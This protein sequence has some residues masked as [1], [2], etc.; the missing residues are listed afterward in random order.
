MEGEKAKLELI[1]PKKQPTNTNQLNALNIQVQQESTQTYA[2]YAE[3]FSEALRNTL[4]TI[5][6]AETFEPTNDTKRCEKCA[7][8]ILCW[9]AKG[10]TN[11]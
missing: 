5:L 4:A 11:Y 6:D 8:K 1:Y 7:Y 3:S 2:Q 9:G 10:I